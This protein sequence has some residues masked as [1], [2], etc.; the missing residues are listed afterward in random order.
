MAMDHLKRVALK[1]PRT[2]FCASEN[3]PE[4]LLCSEHCSEGNGSTG[5][6]VE[7]KVCR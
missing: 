3:A 7:G 1:V 5:N 4:V 6:V 2:D